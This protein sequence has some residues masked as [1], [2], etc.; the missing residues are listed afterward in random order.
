[1]TNISL[2]VSLMVLAIILYS[3]KSNLYIA[4]KT[5]LPNLGSKAVTLC[6]VSIVGIAFSA[7]AAAANLMIAISQMAN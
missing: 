7:T 2:Y 1:M 4:I 3:F 5:K 6:M